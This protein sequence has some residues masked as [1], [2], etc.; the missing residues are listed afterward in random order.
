[1]TA[2]EASLTST[3]CPERLPLVGSGAVPTYAWAPT[4]APDGVARRVNGVIVGNR[5][6][7]WIDWDTPDLAVNQLQGMHFTGYLM[8]GYRYL[9]GDHAGQPGWS[10][11]RLLSH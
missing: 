2:G 11:L 5:I 7:F 8:R 6:D 9:A 10:H 4:T 1:M 3:T